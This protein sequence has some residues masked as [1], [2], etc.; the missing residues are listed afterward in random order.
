MK[1]CKQC[2]RAIKKKIVENRIIFKCI[3][4]YLENTDPED[5]LINHDTLTSNEN[6]EM[7]HNL[8][9]FA[10]FD[11]TNE[12]IKQDCPNCGLDYFTQIRVGSSEIIIYKCKC[13]YKIIN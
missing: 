12:L 2:E 11:R 13:G 9:H 1:F 3:C 8:I 4:G 6:P 10:P 5:V 7:Y